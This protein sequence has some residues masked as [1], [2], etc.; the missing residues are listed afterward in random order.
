MDDEQSSGVLE[1]EATICL[2]VKMR[3][4]RLHSRRVVELPPLS[5]CGSV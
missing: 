4:T 2:P 1:G 3:T 5:S